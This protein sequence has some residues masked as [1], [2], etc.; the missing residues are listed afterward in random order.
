MRSN[1]DP[2]TNLFSLLQKL[3][4]G[5]VDEHMYIMWDMYSDTEYFQAL[6]LKQ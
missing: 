6:R 1:G 4:I 3:G 2:L 5:A